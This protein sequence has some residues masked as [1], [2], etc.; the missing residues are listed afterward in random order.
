MERLPN[1][2]ITTEYME[3][4]N[5][6]TKIV[7]SRQD[8][9]SIIWFNIYS[10]VDSSGIVGKNDV[11]GILMKRLA[12]ISVHSIS[13]A[14]TEQSVWYQQT[15][16]RFAFGQTVEGFGT[17][18]KMLIEEEKTFRLRLLCGCLRAY[19][20]MLLPYVNEV[21]T[22]WAST[23]GGLANWE[24]VYKKHRSMVQQMICLIKKNGGLHDSESS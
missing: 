19:N 4:E 6:M 14:F 13:S 17:Y 5:S 11:L 12:G 9:I 21:I 20:G 22:E 3:L 1:N 8:S 16:E 2:D 7:R 18:W 10:L 24:T 15:I 23:Q